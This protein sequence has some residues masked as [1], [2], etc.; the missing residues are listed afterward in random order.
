[1]GELLNRSY[2]ITY[3]WISYLNSLW[4][5]FDNFL[6]F[7][8]S[9][10]CSIRGWESRHCASKSLLSHNLCFRSLVVLAIGGDTSLEPRHPLTKNRQQ[11]NLF[12]AL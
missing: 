7:A 1:L 6:N 11:G 12:D 2:I 8:I 9:T 4:C 5:Y 3:Q 10:E